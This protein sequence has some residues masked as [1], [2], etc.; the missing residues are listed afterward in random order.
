MNEQFFY[1]NIFLNVLS[2]GLYFKSCH[3]FLLLLLFYRYNETDTNHS[4]LKMRMKIILLP[5]RSI[6]SINLFFTFPVY[7]VGKY[8]FKNSRKKNLFDFISRLCLLNISQYIINSIRS[9]AIN[10]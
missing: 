3:K 7:L 2:T 1:E 9:N 5:I 10:F 6:M 8:L 4:T